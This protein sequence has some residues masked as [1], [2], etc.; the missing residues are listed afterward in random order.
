MLVYRNCQPPPPLLRGGGFTADGCARGGGELVEARP[1]KRG[2]VEA[3]AVSPT[4]LRSLHAGAGGGDADSVATGTPSPLTASSAAREARNPAVMSPVL[5]PRRRVRAADRVARSA[6]RGAGG[7]GVEA[8]G[9]GVRG[10]FGA[11]QQGD[12]LPSGLVPRDGGAAMRVRQRRQLVPW[13]RG[14]A[15]GGVSRVPVERRI[16][17]EALPADGGARLF[18]VG[19]HYCA[20]GASRVYSQELRG[21]VCVTGTAHPKEA[22]HELL[23]EA[24]VI[25]WHI[26]VQRTDHQ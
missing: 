17:K 14:A 5:P 12:P 23:L 11:L 13:S 20:A 24:I 7:A 19:P 16:V 3:A 21:A 25:F 15:E 9:G 10:V 2:S 26:L 1:G 18:D 8:D 22:R 4:P 6:G